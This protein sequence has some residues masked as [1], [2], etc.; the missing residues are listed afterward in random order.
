MSDFIEK[1]H[2]IAYRVT[3][4]L[5]EEIIT[6]KIQAGSHIS[7]KEIADR[8]NVS[9]MPVRE[10]LRTLE[11]EN[12]LKIN[13]YKGATVLAI[14]RAVIEQIYGLLRAIE[15]LIYETA[16][17]RIPPSV[18][19]ELHAINQRI[20]AIG[21]IGLSSAGYIEANSLFHEII[22]Q[23][24]N[25]KK[26]VEHYTYYHDFIKTLRDNYRPSVERVKEAAAEHELLLS[27]LESGDTIALKLAVDAHVK[28]AE[29]NFISLY[30]DML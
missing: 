24:S 5:R 17:G 2:T 8:Y 22:M 10:A 4:K 25:N 7:I 11:G 3:Q 14:D 16:M 27:A 18:F 29:R 9:P 15:G 13:A 19:E 23:Y 6:Q 26:A 12:L 1:E 21:E 28:N 20:T 30:G